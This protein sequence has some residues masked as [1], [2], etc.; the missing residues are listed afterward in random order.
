MGGMTIMALAEQQPALFGERVIAVALVATSPGRLAEVTFGAPAAAGRALRRAAPKALAAL[1]R[2][3]A[4]VAEP[5][6]GCGHRVRA[7]QALLVRRPTCRRRWCGSSRGCTT[8][9]RW[10]CSPSCSRR[11]TRTTSST[12]CGSSTASRR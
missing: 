8:R 11:S 9:P 1:N 10:T 7:D 12:R 5:V 3:P 2:R 4:L 6:V